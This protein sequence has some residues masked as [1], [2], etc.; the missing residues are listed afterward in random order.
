MRTPRQP[1]CSEGAPRLAAQ[2]L[3]HQPVVVVVEREGPLRHDG[4]L[5]CPYQDRP[6]PRR[7]RQQ[8]K[9]LDPRQR[10]LGHLPLHV[11]P[12]GRHARLLKGCQRLERHDGRHPPEHRQRPPRHLLARLLGRQQSARRVAV[13]DPPAG[14]RPDERP[15]VPRDALSGRD[16]PVDATAASSRRLGDGLGWLHARGLECG[17]LRHNDD[18]DEE[19]TRQGVRHALGL[20][21]LSG[22]PPSDARPHPDHRPRRQEARHEPARDLQRRVRPHMHARYG[23]YDDQ[24][25]GAGGEPGLAERVG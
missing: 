25:Q 21:N 1:T 20:A 3:N 10:R 6:P 22:A 2:L 12:H 16:G 18:D 17:V 7:Q 11:A 14:R 8:R 9:V 23:C 4:R 13:V 15:R 5:G 19:G 24:R